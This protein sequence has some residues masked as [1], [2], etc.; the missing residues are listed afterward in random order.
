M[1]ENYVQN[2]YLPAMR[3]SERSIED[4]ESKNLRTVDDSKSLFGQKILRLAALAQDDA[5]C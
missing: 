1:E 4:A 3:H 5:V 2:F